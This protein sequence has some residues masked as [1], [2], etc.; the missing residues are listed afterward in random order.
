MLSGTQEPA[1]AARAG[2]LNGG[3]S[4]CT[5]LYAYHYC[6][7]RCL[8]YYHSILLFALLLLL[9]LIPILPLILVL[10]GV[11]ITAAV[12]ACYFIDSTHPGNVRDGPQGG[13]RSAL[14]N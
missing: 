8:H 4:P 1:A 14:F 5:K 10:R 2:S 12:A 3:R 7:H 13:N 11:T 9:W 6:Y